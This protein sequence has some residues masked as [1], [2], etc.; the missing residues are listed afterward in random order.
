MDSL[1]EGSTFPELTK[2]QAS[3]SSTNSLCAP[4]AWQFPW[5]LILEPSSEFPGKAKHQRKV[6]TS[7]ESSHRVD[8]LKVV[9][10][11]TVK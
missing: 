7:Q 10:Q 1:Q 9:V 4:V 5:Q 3:S 11:V 8:L 2:I 6:Q